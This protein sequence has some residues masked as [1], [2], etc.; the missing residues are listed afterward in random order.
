MARNDSNNLIN[1]EVADINGYGVFA[2]AIQNQQDLMID[3]IKKQ[4]NDKKPMR[5]HANNYTF[6]IE[7][8]RE[9]KNPMTM[10]PIKT[11]K[12][13]RE[14]K[15]FYENYAKEND[16]RPKEGKKKAQFSPMSYV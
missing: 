2:K 11:Y 4:N 3:S 14:Q 9:H 15:S 10:I 16:K 7:N 13:T 8:P 5:R 1:D 6:P 12:E